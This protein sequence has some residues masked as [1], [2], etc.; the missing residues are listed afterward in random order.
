MHSGRIDGQTAR[1]HD[2]RFHCH[3]DGLNVELFR[4]V[5]AVP[6][7]IQLR[8]RSCRRIDHTVKEQGTL[9][10]QDDEF[11][12]HE[13]LDPGPALASPRGAAM[14]SSRM[15]SAK[16]HGLDIGHVDCSLNCFHG[17]AH[18]TQTHLQTISPVEPPAPAL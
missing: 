16:T 14:S 15:L 1:F 7:L 6:G 8:R 9:S 18:E 5:G 3:R 11:A 2:W 4:T 13:N 10:I 17:R 12:T